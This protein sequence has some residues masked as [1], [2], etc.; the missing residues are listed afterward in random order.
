MTCCSAENELCVVRELDE[1][2]LR[3][4]CRTH[5]NNITRDVEKLPCR[6]LLL[7]DCSAGLQAQ[8]RQ[9][10][11][12]QSVLIKRENTEWAFESRNGK[13]SRYCAVPTSATGVSG[14]RG[15]F[16]CFESLCREKVG[17]VA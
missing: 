11:K 4:L 2:R 6:R 7:D 5:K 1:V 17:H 14:N 12:C 13:Q 9:D 8:D 3:R 16:H 15:K 10:A